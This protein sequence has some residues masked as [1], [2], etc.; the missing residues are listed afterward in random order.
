MIYKDS[1]FAKEMKQA[2]IDKSA[3]KRQQ[4]RFGLFL[5]V[6]SF[7]VYFVLQTLTKSVLTDAVPQFMLPSY[8]STLS[9]YISFVYVC[10][11]VYFLVN[12][13]YLTF[14]EIRL[15][16]WYM[17]VNMGFNPLTMILEKLAARA[18]SILMVYSIGF[19]TTVLLTTFLKYP[20]VTDYMFGM[21]IAGFADLVLI[22]MVTMA[23]SLFLRVQSTAKYVVAAMACALFIVK[24][25]SGYNGVVT[26]RAL[27]GNIVNLFTLS[28]SW[29]MVFA[30]ALL[31]ACLVLTVVYARKYARKYSFSFYRKDLDY[32][33][34]VNIVVKK[35]DSFK[36][37]NKAAYTAR[38][39]KTL[40]DTAAGAVM[41]C[42]II[43]LLA[44]NA[45]VL[46]LSMSAPG[47]EAAVFGTIP[48]IFQS[49][50][51]QP[52]LM[53]NDLIFFKKLEPSDPAKVDDIVIYKSNDQVGIS[54]IKKM[55]KGAI[56]VNV[57]YYNPNGEADEF[58]EEITRGDIYGRYEGRSRWLG[59]LILLANSVFGRLA[60]MLVPVL[61]I[62]YYKPIIGF[63]GKLR[64]VEY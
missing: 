7:A 32:P 62:F 24:V 11:A 44:F 49:D 63:F 19:L 50:T 18:A 17:L 29:Y 42:V 23:A 26:D 45:L 10:M 1:F 40:L 64:K 52:V 61:L 55:D 30:A 57:D 59:A 12:Y 39:Q 2:H 16:R 3:G 46:V 37:V 34:D 8:F 51:M 48:Y 54:R 21:Y 43:A 47:K 60:F 5:A 20:L 53:N 25:V 33:S 9:V 36:D 15:N 13:R 38:M 28:R 22:A 35:G 6:G 4:I 56:T 27:M 31:A 41:A 58:L 14:A